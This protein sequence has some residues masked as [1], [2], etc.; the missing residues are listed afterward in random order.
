[1]K[2]IRVVSGV[3]LGVLLVSAGAYAQEQAGGRKGAGKPPVSKAAK[4]DAR[5]A[6]Q[7]QREAA[8]RARA[9]LEARQRAEAEAK[10]LAEIEVR[11]R[12]L[13]EA[14]EL[15]RSGKP[16][17]A[18]ALLEPLEFERAGE[19][20]FDYLLSIAALDSGKPDKATL[21]FERVLAV[22]P[23]FV[24]ARLDMA[25]AYYQLG[26]L[27][28]AKTEFE[29]VKGQN[30]PDAAKATIGKYLDA[31]AAQED[32]KQTRVS[33]YLEGA[34]GN[35]SNVNA[36]TNQSQISLP[37]F[38][39]LVVGLSPVNVKT[40]DN[41]YGLAAG[42][43]ASHSLDGGW[44]LYAGADARQRGNMT[45][46]RFDSTA[47]DGRAG[48]MFGAEANMV[49][50]GV[51]GGQYLLNGMPNRDSLGFN[52]EWRHTFSPSNQMMVFGQNTRYRY[53]D[54][55]MKTNDF[56]QDIVG[57]GWLHVLPDGKSALFGSL[58]HGTERD[59]AP[60]S[61]ANPAGGRIDG[62]KRLDGLR[63]GGQYS[64]REDVELFGS[65]GWQ[66]GSYGKVNAIFLRQR[67]DRQHDLTLGANWHWDRLWTVRPQLTYLR[68][69]SNIVIYSYD[70]V[71]VS[72]AIR[73]D[74]K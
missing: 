71:D 67:S 42:G 17:E 18:Y 31:I 62:A 49:R 54:V 64:L 38:G 72:L 68:N 20:R 2:L 63:A 14:D 16:S 19:V 65:L 56:D 73:R 37:A 8:A 28:R 29:T 27:A 3:S 50:A 57:A 74:F 69:E 23:N 47:L 26:D 35:D 13:R 33:A 15:I 32:V 9:E 22:D 7:A 44:G 41:Y 52:V 59:V 10:R 5:A 34:L 61:A 46:N 12:P 43:E 25:R 70:R 58:Y 53:A 24:G 36:S 55:A 4:P 48:V 30:P 21:G 6:Q 51:S 40:A 60:I 66:E 45:Q 11:E 1:M 39:N